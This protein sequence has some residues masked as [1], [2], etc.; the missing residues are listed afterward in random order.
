MDE[1]RWI[2]ELL[3]DLKHKKAMLSDSFQIV[4]NNKKT[5]YATRNID[6]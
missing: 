6:N 1:I 4:K 3:L 5:S 2:N